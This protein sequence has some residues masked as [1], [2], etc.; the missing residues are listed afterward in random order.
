MTSG[1]SVFHCLEDIVA[2]ERMPNNIPGSACEWYREGYLDRAERG[3][4]VLDSKCSIQVG[5][6]EEVK[7]WC[8]VYVWGVTPAPSSGQG[9]LGFGVGCTDYFFW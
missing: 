1:N 9:V 7:G 8:F 2:T 5:I 3:D 6:L 4:D